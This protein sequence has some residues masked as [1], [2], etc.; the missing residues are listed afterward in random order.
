MYALPVRSINLAVISILE[1]TKNPV[2]GNAPEPIKQETD[3]IIN[4]NIVD[5]VVNKY[6][7]NE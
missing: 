1:L 3:I 7:D 5:N 4:Y 6:E 2:W